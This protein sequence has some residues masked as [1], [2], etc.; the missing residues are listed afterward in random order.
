VADWLACW[1]V[2]SSLVTIKASRIGRSR[3][4]PCGARVSQTSATISL[5]TSRSRRSPVHQRS[6]ALAEA[7]GT[8]LGAVLNRGPSVARSTGSCGQLR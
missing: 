6:E 5:T 2:P 4:S 3:T 8:V 1:R 7:G